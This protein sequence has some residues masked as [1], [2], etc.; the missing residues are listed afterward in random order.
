MLFISVE[1]VFD[2]LLKTDNVW[3]HVFWMGQNPSL[4]Y[5]DI[6]PVSVYFLHPTEERRRSQLFDLPMA[7]PQLLLGTV[8]VSCSACTIKCVTSSPLGSTVFVLIV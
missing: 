3:G 1:Q 2:L 6:N 4:N 7:Y 8:I 5:D